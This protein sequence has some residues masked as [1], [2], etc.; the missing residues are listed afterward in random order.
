MRD[1]T[2]FSSRSIGSLPPASALRNCSIGS[3][4]LSNLDRSK[5]AV[6]TLPKSRRWP[7]LLAVL[8]RLYLSDLDEN[9]WDPFAAGLARGRPLAV[10][11]LAIERFLGRC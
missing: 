10:L 4:A 3:R 2:A 8:S 5:N 7:F 11:H 9:R 6:R 1:S